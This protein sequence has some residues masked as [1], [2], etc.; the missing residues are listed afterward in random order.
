MLIEEHCKA[1]RQD[2]EPVSDEAL[3]DF[4]TS[5]PHWVCKE[6]SGI[7]KLHREFTFPNYAQAVAF[8]NQVANL[9]ELEDHHP[10]MLLQWGKVT[11]T[12]WTHSINGLHKN[13]FIMAAKSEALMTD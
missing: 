6:E 11:L 10:D 12:W 13:D 4:L 9:A 8:T 1:C 3:A 5:H 2:A 7:L